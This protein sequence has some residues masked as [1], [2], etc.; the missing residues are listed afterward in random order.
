M[1]RQFK[2]IAV[3]LVPLAVIVFLTST[4]VVNEAT[5]STA[6]FTFAATFNQAVY[7]NAGGTLDRIRTG[8]EGWRDWL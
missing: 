7:M 4:K 5:D 1:R 3:I 8:P 2:T 6:A